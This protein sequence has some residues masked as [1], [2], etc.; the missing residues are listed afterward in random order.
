MVGKR[1]L[2]LSSQSPPGPE[3][4]YQPNALELQPPQPLN[5]SAAQNSDIS[6]LLSEPL[7]NGSNRLLNPS[8]KK[9]S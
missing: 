1:D 2:L 8:E 6:G 9:Q 3:H 5:Q 4:S 7:S